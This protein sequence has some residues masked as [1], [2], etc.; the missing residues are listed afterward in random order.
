MI[1]TG[2][3]STLGRWSRGCVLHTCR[4]LHVA[5]DAPPGCFCAVSDHHWVVDDRHPVDTQMRSTHQLVLTQGQRLSPAAFL[6]H[7]GCFY[8]LGDRHWVVTTTRSMIA[9]MCSTHSPMSTNSWELS[10]AAFLH[11]TCAH[12]H[13]VIDHQCRCTSARSHHPRCTRSHT[14]STAP[15]NSLSHSLSPHGTDPPIQIG[16]ENDSNLRRRFA[17]KIL[18]KCVSASNSPFSTFLRHF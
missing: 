1:A 16:F 9:P 17:A 15:V 7:L 14:R 4:G 2:W 13:P 11:H 8:A 10:P 3:S 18:R 6:T 5:R 12:M